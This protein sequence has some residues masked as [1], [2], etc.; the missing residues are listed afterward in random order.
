VKAVLIHSTHTHIHTDK[1]SSL[2]PILLKTCCQDGSIQIIKFSINLIPSWLSLSWN[3]CSC[4]CHLIPPVRVCVFVSVEGRRKLIQFYKRRDN[5]DDVVEGGHDSNLL[6]PVCIRSSHIYP[7]LWGL[8][9][10][11]PPLHR[12]NAMKF[13][14]KHWIS[15]YNFSNFNSLSKLIHT[16]LRVYMNQTHIHI[17]EYS[18]KYKVKQLFI[19]GGESLSFSIKSIWEKLTHNFYADSKLQITPTLHPVSK[20][21][22]DLLSQ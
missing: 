13:S 12:R 11:L 19:L 8:I 22:R 14:S 1:S 15:S 21:N 7:T 17:R 5:Y 6:P 4:L 16:N 20:F 10:L 3:W 2:H 9:K 18:W